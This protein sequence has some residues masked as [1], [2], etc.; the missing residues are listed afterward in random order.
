MMDFKKLFATLPDKPLLRIDQVAD[1]FGVTKKTIYSWYPDK[2]QG[3]N[4]NGVIR[5]YRVSVE[6]LVKKNHARKNG[7]D[8]GDA[9]TQTI[10]TPRGRRVLSVGVKL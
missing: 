9:V 7:D 2:L 4:V 8:S 6:E 1:F 10:N 3:I 5:I